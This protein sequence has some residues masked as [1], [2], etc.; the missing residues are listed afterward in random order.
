M[1]VAID[2]P[3]NFIFI[4]IK[5]EVVK[6]TYKIINIAVDLREATACMH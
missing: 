3:R 2:P 6:Q 4:A 1:L 5:R